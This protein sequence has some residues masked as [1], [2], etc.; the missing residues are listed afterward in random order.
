MKK[1]KPST[2]IVNFRP[3]LAKVGV[4]ALGQAKTVIVVLS[5]PNEVWRHIVFVRFFFFFF[6]PTLNLFVAFI[7]DG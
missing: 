1:I 4:L 2:K 7:R 3:P 5:L 6:F